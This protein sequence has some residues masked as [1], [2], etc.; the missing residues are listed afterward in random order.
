M[1]IAYSDDNEALRQTLRSYY[2]AL[3]RPEVRRRL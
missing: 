3:L 2:D 1:Y